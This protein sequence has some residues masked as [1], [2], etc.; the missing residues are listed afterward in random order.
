[1]LPT[2]QNNFDEIILLYIKPNSLFLLQETD[3]LFILCVGEKLL[4]RC[5]ACSLRILF[6]DGALFSLDA[7]WI[8]SLRGENYFCFIYVVSSKMKFYCKSCKMYLMLMLVILIQ[9]CGVWGNNRGD[10][11]YF[12]YSRNVFTCS[13]CKKT[14]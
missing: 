12:T 2:R 1:M 3:A 7:D 14:N 10:L 8:V 6:L 9:L 11:N 5:Y 13:R 4:V